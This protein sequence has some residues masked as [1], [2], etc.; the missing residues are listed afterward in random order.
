MAVGFVL[1]GIG[2]VGAVVPVLPTTIFFIGAAACFARSSPR[3]ERWVL[4][5][6]HVGPLV[7]DYRSGLGMPR[8]AKVTASAAIAM[9]ITISAIALTSWP[10]RGVA[11]GLG[12]IGIAYVTFVVPTRERVLADRALASGSVVPVPVLLGPDLSGGRGT[13]SAAAAGNGQTGNDHHSQQE[14]H[15]QGAR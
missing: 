3:L 7:R 5:L 2:G 15:D 8:R 11:A 9:A 10:G 14:Q 12:L 4:E 13:R 1:V 6:P